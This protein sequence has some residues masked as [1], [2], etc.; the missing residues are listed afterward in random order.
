MKFLFT[1]KAQ[2]DYEEF[3]PKL[4]KLIDKQIT[5]LLE[6]IRHPSLRAKKY[7]ESRDVWQMR[8]SRDY[9]L[10]ISRLKMMYI[11]F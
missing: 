10:F 8:V 7:D 11:S 6:N 3:S 9:R 1:K 4:K 5:A 2:K